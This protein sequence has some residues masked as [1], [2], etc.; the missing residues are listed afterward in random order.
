MTAAR[1]LGMTVP[2]RPIAPFGDTFAGP[3]AWMPLTGNAHWLTFRRAGVPVIS[4]HSGDGKTLA[5][6]FDFDAYYAQYRLLA[7]FIALIDS[8]EAKRSSAA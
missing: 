8:R 3:Y 7:V 4:I 2:P 6:R 5:P 1:T